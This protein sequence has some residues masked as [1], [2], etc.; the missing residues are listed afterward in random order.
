MLYLCGRSLVEAWVCWAQLCCRAVSRSGLHSPCSHR[1]A[2]SEAPEAPAL[3][4]SEIS[5]L[6]GQDESLFTASQV[7]KFPLDITAMPT[8]P[9]IRQ[10]G[11]L[12]SPWKNLQ[13]PNFSHMRIQK[14]DSCSSS[15]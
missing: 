3:M 13:V 5:A 11:H 8:D 10:E 15:P 1:D 14:T 9:S 6:K 7:G 2:T 4:H 12:Q